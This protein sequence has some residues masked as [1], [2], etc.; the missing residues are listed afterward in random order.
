MPSS[1]IFQTQRLKCME[2]SHLNTNIHCS[3]LR[4]ACIGIAM[5]AGEKPGDPQEGFM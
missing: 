3:E 2:V 1:A 4:Y 5:S